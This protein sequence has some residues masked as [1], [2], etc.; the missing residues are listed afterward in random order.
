MFWII[1]QNF[2][3]DLKIDF[4]NFIKSIPINILVD[5]IKENSNGIFYI[6]GIREDTEKLD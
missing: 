6:S 3:N 2:N 5:F 4:E 1:C